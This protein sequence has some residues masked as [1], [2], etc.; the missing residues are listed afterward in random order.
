M[1]EATLWLDDEGLKE[2]TRKVR[3]SA[4]IKVLNAMHIDHRTRPDGSIVVLKSALVD[5]K[6]PANK[7]IEPNMEAV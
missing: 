4:Q 3:P 7:K 1:S 6:K 2:L 5:Y